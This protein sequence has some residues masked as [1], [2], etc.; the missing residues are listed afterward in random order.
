MICFYQ[1]FS[2]PETVSLSGRV[3]SSWWEHTSDIQNW[4]HSNLLTQLFLELNGTQCLP[5]HLSVSQWTRKLGR[6]GLEHSVVSQ[7]PPV[8]L[9]FSVAWLLLFYASPALSFCFW[10]FLVLLHP[11]VHFQRICM[12]LFYIF[13]FGG[14]NFVRARR[15]CLGIEAWQILWATDM[16]QT[17]PAN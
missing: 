3:N 4:K 5:M 1:V 9:I 17:Q 16:G 6:L 11:Q 14:N 15:R 8:I 13:L 7:T 12:E 10:T 2:G